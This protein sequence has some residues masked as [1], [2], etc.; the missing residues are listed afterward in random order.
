MSVLLL[1]DTRRAILKH[2][3]ML[4]SE[5]DCR[6]SNDSGDS[7][8]DEDRLGSEGQEQRQDRSDQEGGARMTS[9]RR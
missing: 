4:I 7:E 8:A 1:L 6:D 5:D 3:S 2:S 9:D